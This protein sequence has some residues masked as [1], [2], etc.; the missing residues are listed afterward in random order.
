M[1]E[2]AAVNRG[3]EGSSP[4]S[5]ANVCFP[6]SRFIGMEPIAFK[7]ELA[8]PVLQPFFI[9]SLAK[10]EMLPLVWTFVLNIP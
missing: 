7:S 5:G 3:V 9:R 6:F 1:V 10:I 2:H 8:S 4:S